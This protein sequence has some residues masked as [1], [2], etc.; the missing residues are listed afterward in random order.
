MVREG[1]KTKKVFSSIG[2]GGT[3][4]P[5]G[6]PQAPLWSLANIAAN[7][8]RGAADILHD[9]AIILRSMASI[10]NVVPDILHAQHHFFQS[11][12]KLV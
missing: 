7:I 4:G 3:L 6:A 1:F 2:V 10:L 9:A 12:Q 11:A 8:M 5:W